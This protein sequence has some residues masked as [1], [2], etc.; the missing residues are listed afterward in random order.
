MGEC[1]DGDRL[2]VVRR[3]EVATVERGTAAGQLEQGQ[4]TAR[5]R[6]DLDR[7]RFAGRRDDVEDVLL[8]LV[9][10][11]QSANDLP[12]PST[13]SGW[14]DRATVVGSAPS[15]IRSSTSRSSERLG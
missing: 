3:D 9:V 14:T 5:R 2:D 13:R 12:G 6:A 15:V 4:R 1:R 7:L 8:D 10:D 11:V